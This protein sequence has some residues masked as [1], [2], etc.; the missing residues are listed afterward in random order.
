MRSLMTNTG[1]TADL[2]ERTPA[3]EGVE[4]EAAVLG[5]VAG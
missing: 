3:A 4:Y 5:G 2:M 1:W